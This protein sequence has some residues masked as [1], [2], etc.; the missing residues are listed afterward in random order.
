LAVTVRNLDS[1]V[2]QAALVIGS[3]CVR[4]GEEQANDGDRNHSYDR[5][6]IGTLTHNK[7]LGGGGI[8]VSERATLLET[9]AA[10]VQAARE[11]WET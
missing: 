9:F 5:G 7:A 4:G 8:A 3:I 10:L 6:G 11:A 1:W 2:N